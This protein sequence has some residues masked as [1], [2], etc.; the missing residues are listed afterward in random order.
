MQENVLIYQVRSRNRDPLAKM[1]HN[2]KEGYEGSLI[3]FYFIA[4]RIGHSFHLN[5]RILWLEFNA[6]ND[7]FIATLSCDIVILTTPHTLCIR[8][9]FCDAWIP[10]LVLFNSNWCNC[11]LIHTKGHQCAEEEEGAAVRRSSEDKAGKGPCRRRRRSAAFRKAFRNT[12]CLC[13]KDLVVG[14]A[15]PSGWGSDQVWVTSDY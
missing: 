10:L 9:T 11:H 14:L 6:R 7:K 4:C 1:C 15:L 12:S 13:S 5:Q 2:T 3:N 8:L